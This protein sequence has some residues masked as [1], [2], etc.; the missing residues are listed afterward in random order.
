MIAEPKCPS[1]GVQGRDSFATTE[2]RQQSQGGETWFEIVH[3]AGC[4]HV[5][6]IITKVVRGPT[7]NIP[8]ID[9]SYRP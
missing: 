3:C 7:I 1:C 8:R 2:S 5:Y 6:G 9:P 4:G